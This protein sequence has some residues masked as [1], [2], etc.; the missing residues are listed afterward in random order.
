[1]RC[2][3][4]SNGEWAEAWVVVWEVVWEEVAAAVEAAAEMDRGLEAETTT[5]GIT[6]VVDGEVVITEVAGGTKEIM[7]HQ[8]SLVLEVTTREAMETKVLGKE[9][10]PITRTGTVK[11][12]KVDGVPKL[13]TTVVVV[14]AVV[15]PL[16][17]GAREVPMILATITDRATE[18]DQCETRDTRTTDLL[19]TVLVVAEVP[20]AEG[21]MQAV[22]GTTEI[23][24]T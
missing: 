7:V 20:V 15:V 24:P 16:I 22:Q 14:G 6:R 3:F 8:T 17:T 23:H 2:R 13:E 9:A 4:S 11:I 21:T 18:E 5:G 19:H 1:M 12:A 10:L